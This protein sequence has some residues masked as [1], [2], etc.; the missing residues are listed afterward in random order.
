[1]KTRPARLL[2]SALVEIANIRDVC[3]ERFNCAL[4]KMNPKVFPPIYE[5]S[6]SYLLTYTGKKYID[7][8]KLFKTTACCSSSTN[9]DCCADLLIE[10]I[11]ACV[12]K[13]VCK[14]KARILKPRRWKICY[15]N[16]KTNSTVVI[17]TKDKITIT[18]YYLSKPLPWYDFQYS[19]HYR[20]SHEDENG[21]V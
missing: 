8:L 10:V 19:V 7:C 14:A 2:T 9:K 13:L 17:S 18:K 1:M 20:L 16:N 3:K 15:I 6:G 12:T 4:T 11:S 5:E 21:K